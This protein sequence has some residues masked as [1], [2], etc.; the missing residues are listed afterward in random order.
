MHDYPLKPLLPPNQKKI[1]NMALQKMI[2]SYCFPLKCYRLNGDL[3]PALTST[4]SCMSAARGERRHIAGAH[5]TRATFGSRCATCW[6]WFL[7]GTIV[8]MVF[9]QSGKFW[10]LRPFIATFWEDMLFRQG[11]DR[12]GMFM[13]DI[14]HG[15]SCLCFE[16][17]IIG[18][19]TLY[20]FCW[21]FL[22]DLL[23]QLRCSQFL[24]EC[25]VFSAP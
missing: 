11:W 24:P 25:S 21:W 14:P 4:S 16:F 8:W 18:A 2:V 15:V 1:Y 19:Q 20:S 6:H 10:M 12:C 7:I 3:G 22:I 23:Y 13:F 9:L 5:K 17:K